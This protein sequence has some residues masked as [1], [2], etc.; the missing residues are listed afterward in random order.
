[1]IPKNGLNNRTAD[2]IITIATADLIKIMVEGI[3][4]ITSADLILCSGKSAFV[5]FT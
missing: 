5:I 2:S 1:M 4:I 3:I